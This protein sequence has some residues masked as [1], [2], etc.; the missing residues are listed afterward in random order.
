MPWSAPIEA[1]FWSIVAA[2]AK[3]LDGFIQVVGTIG[4]S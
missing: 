1:R 2:T 4:V 3:K